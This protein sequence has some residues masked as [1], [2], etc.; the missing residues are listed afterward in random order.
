MNKPRMLITGG[1]GY[2][3]GWVARLART[4]WDVTATYFVHSVDEPDVA[5]HRLDLRDA[6]AVE[7]PIDRV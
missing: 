3:G 7:A 5:W 2:L 6:A 4:D 1:S